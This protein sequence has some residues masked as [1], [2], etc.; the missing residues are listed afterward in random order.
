MPA[1]P[2][3]SAG[4][5]SEP[6]VS[7]PRPQGAMPGGKGGKGMAG[8]AL[9]QETTPSDAHRWTPLL[10]V[11]TPQNVKVPERTLTVRGDAATTKAQRLSAVSKGEGL[12]AGRRW[13]THA[14]GAQRQ[15]TVACRWWGRRGRR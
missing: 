10:R 4:I 15:R 14:L 3:R 7:L 8:G 12:G 9:G 2:Q 6:A 5:R 13:Q 1:T 11:R